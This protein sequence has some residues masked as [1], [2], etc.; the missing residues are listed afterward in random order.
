MDHAHMAQGGL[1][2]YPC[3]YGR[4]RLLFRGPRRRLDGPYIAA[5]GSTE[6]YGKYVEIPYPALL[7]QSLGGRV[8]NLGCLHA[9]VSIFVE[10]ETVLGAC[11]AAEL[12]IVQVMS[13]HNMSNRLYTV[14]PR[15]NDRF[16]KASSDLRKLYPTVDFTDFHFT[17]HLLKTLQD[18]SDSAFDA[19]RAELKEAWTRRMELLIDRIG[20]P[21]V[22]LWMSHRMPEDPDDLIHGGDPLYVDR[23]MIEALRPHVIDIVEAVATPEARDEG[24]EN[25]IFAEID[26]PAALGVPGPLFHAETAAALA[27]AMP[28]RFRRDGSAAHPDGAAD[29]AGQSFSISSGTAVKRSATSP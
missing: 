6:T 1:N 11:A 8:V 29:A 2:Y 9:G 22:L 4:S 18:L 28:A 13:A 14:H 10:D 7:E 20:G 23:T 5:I 12:T 15:R 26:S 21:V 27:A 3:R 16:L 25:S 24:S 19:V 17:R